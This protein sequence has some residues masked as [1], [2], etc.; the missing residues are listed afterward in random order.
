MFVFS[1]I[2]PDHK[3]LEIRLDTI[4]APCYNTIRSDAMV[5]IVAAIVLIVEK[6]L[7]AKNLLQL[8][9]LPRLT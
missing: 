2:D 6:I 4:V 7:T 9:R 3:N 5:T 8:A 1:N